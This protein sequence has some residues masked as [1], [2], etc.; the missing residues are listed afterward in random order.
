MIAVLLAAYN[1]E[2]YLRKQM[3]SILGQETEEKICIVASDDCSRDGTAAI[4]DL[5]AEKFPDQVLALHRKQPSGGADR[6]FL[7]LMQLFACA[8]NAELVGTN[9]EFCPDTVSRL[10][11]IASAQYVMLSDQDDVWLP[12][13]VEKLVSCMRTMERKHSG[14]PIL[15]HS[16]LAVVD[17][18]LR[19]L[20]SS[21]FQYQ[22]VSPRRSRL[23]QLLV[24]N[25][26]TGG[27][28]MI[29]RPFLPLLENIPSCVLM[30]DA[31]LALL[32]AC[33]GATGWVDEPL[34]LYR[35]HMGNSLG[36]Q[37]ADR[38]QEMRER[39]AN[40]SKAR[41]NYRRMFAQAGE[42]LE[43]FGNQLDAGQIA[44]L[45]HFLAIPNQGRLGKMYSILRYGFTKNS[46]LRTLGQ[47]LLIGT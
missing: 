14:A 4:L 33:F 21:F 26:V 25:N 9:W 37:Q 5:Y 15:V 19:V 42:L 44:T 11:Q 18:D 22:R 23:R 29:N 7:E 38:A 39:I 20:A 17:Q 36:A 10:R 3:D 46:L 45:K 12:Q 8:Q 30:H 2:M 47:M 6:H 27:A 35:Q 24:Q 32:A 40:G 16:D 31:W 43:L 34:Y 13:K 41:E 1:G 28:V